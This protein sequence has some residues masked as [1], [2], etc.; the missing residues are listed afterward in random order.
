MLNHSVL[1]RGA[2]IGL[3]L[4]GLVALADGTARTELARAVDASR[5]DGARLIVRIAGAAG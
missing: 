2:L 3:A 1:V 5:S 4:A